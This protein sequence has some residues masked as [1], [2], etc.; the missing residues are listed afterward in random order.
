MSPRLDYLLTS[1]LGVAVILVGAIVALFVAAMLGVF[2]ADGMAWIGLA[3]WAADALGVVVGILVMVV[4][5]L[6]LVGVYQNT[7]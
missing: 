2:V 1:A 3:R 4:E 7:A 5:G 6:Y